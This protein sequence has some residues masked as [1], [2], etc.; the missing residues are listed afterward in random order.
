M[1][2]A[3]PARPVVLYVNG[4]FVRQENGSHA[5]QTELMDFLYSRYPQIV[6]VGFSNHPGAPWRDADIASFSK[7][8][9]K[10][11]LCLDRLGVPE[12]LSANLRNALLLL[13]PQ[14]ADQIAALRLPAVAPNYS[15]VTAELGDA[16]YCLN[17]VDAPSY[18]NGVPLNRSVIDTHDVKF[19]KYRK[20]KQKDVF[21][22]RVIGKLIS[23]AA[24]LR[25]VKSVVAISKKDQEIFDS[26][27]DDVPVRFV[28]IYQRREAVSRERPSQFPYDLAFVG[29]ENEF[30]VV[31]FVDFVRNNRD[32]L[33]RRT[34][35][36]A[37]KVCGDPRV[38]SVASEN[39]GIQLRG[40]VGD[41]EGFLSEAKA[42]LSPV[43]GSGLK[44]KIV[45]ALACGK[46]VFASA[47]S[48]SGLPDGYERCV[49]PLLPAAMDR[50]LDDD[51]A[52]RD[53]EAEARAYFSRFMEAGDLAAFQADLDH[54]VRL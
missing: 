44:I 26:I 39:P 15:R 24:V 45:D 11:R 6:V 1:K 32:W 54:L 36:V 49:L 34:I 21:D 17:Y 27:L 35:A 51:A 46:P 19:Q 5:R 12:K 13:L 40:F 3:A 16:A 53:A 14:R 31:G 4:A 38:Q 29:S 37:G 23:E 30:N 20:L 2:P 8:Y 25:R 7:K 47:H 22:F 48:M 52:L 43:E 41:L 50:L 33:R 18:L 28:P 9:P 42:V 10:A